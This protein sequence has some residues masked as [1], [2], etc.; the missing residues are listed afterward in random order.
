L[1]TGTKTGFKTR[2]PSVAVA[3]RKE[4]YSIEGD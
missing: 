3:F 4:D 1:K 2:T